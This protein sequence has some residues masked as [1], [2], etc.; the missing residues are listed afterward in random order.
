M[1]HDIPSHTAVVRTDFSLTPI[2]FAMQALF[3]G[4]MTLSVLPTTA[5]AAEP[6][7]ATKATRHDFTIP[8]GPLSAAIA[9]FS[10][11]SGTYV[12]VD[13]ALTDGKNSQGVQGS[14]SVPEALNQL[15]SGTGLE[16]HAQANG[17]YVLRVAPIA[18]STLPAISV[19][20]DVITDPTK[21]YAGGQVARGGSLG[22]LGT[23]DVMDVPF[24]VTNYTSQALEDQQ[25]RTLADVVVN[26][27]SVR[28]T[29]ASNGFADTFQIRGFKVDSTDVGFNGLYGLIPQSHVPAQLIERV[30]VLKGPGALMNGIAPTGSVGGGINIVSKRA[31]DA[32]L[33][34]V[35]TMYTGKANFGVGIDVGRRFGQDNAWGVRFNGLVRDGEASIDDGNQQSSVGALGIDYRGNRMRWSL[36]AIVQR[37]DTDEFR[38]QIS[39]N[40]GLL[41][42]PKPP[43]ARSNWFPGTTLVQKDS[44]IA[45]SIEYDLTDSL[46]AYAGIG[47]R[48]GTNDQVFPGATAVNAA[49]DFT[50]GNNFYDSY[51][52]VTS[53]NAGLRWKF[54]TAGVSHTLTAAVTEMRQKSG[55]AYITGNAAPSNIYNPVPLPSITSPRTSPNK[56]AETT[57]SSFAIA[58]TIS[59]MN[60]RLLITI[61]ARNQNV[62]VEDFDVASGASIGNYNESAVSPLA[63]IVFKPVDNISVYGNYT[64]GLSK[65]VT[66][67]PD[68][69]NR[70][71]SLAPYKSE[72]YEAGV[73]VDWGRVTTTAAIY[74]ISRPNGQG[75]VGGAYSYSGEQRNRGLELTAYGELRR[76]LRGIVSAAFTDPELTKA[77]AGLNEGND[78]AG[79]PDLTASA[80]L[81]WDTPWVPGLALNGRVIYTS[82]AYL[83]TANDQKF[84]S[85]TRVDIGARYRTAIGGKQVVFRA[86]IEN[87][88]DK[89]YWLTEG[90]Y[91]TVGAPRTAV[92]S[93]SIDF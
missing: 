51:S 12:S 14:L 58:D 33:T 22:L 71:T 67:G 80:S 49:G 64:E 37:D 54:D 40:G 10:A 6:L 87:L 42:I 88:F 92:L 39:L 75:V 76:G 30:E 4:A 45:T 72:Q 81:D 34:R 1:K 65:G 15:L 74:Q 46:M 89:D 27:A 56:S 52:K 78:A 2:A 26:D 35:T 84:D 62:E 48:D 43:D 77:P 82:G 8:A 25:A 36:D 47:Y 93:A 57:L 24:S 13:G 55:Y 59:F 3:V 11:Q 90:T 69:S 32:P 5:F 38:P 73:K 17:S 9:R 29:T 53:A 21:P 16:A 60:D 19:T 28:L 83:T 7:S 20:G 70:G 79:V 41:A 85:W 91:V 66:V 18:A 63:G 68:Y 86:N 50:V 31:D 23:Q 61:G 44:I